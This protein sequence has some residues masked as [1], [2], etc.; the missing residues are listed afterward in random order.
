M[1]HTK[2][3]AASAHLVVRVGVLTISDTRTEETDKSGTLMKQLLTEH[4]FVVQHYAI[5]KDEPSQ[6]RQQIEAWI[7][8]TNS[9]LD[10]AKPDVILTNGGT[11]ISKRDSTY[12][13]VSALLEKTLTGF[14]ELFRMLSYHEIGASAMLSRATAGVYRDT[15]L[16]ATPGSTHAVRLA[17]EKLILPEMKHLVW[18]LL[19]QK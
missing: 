5:V 1:P 16:F 7:G 11:G 12:E 2:H 17:M 18:E 10:G 19:R 13:V 4:G 9:N 3:H 8:D 6:I 15:L 14:G